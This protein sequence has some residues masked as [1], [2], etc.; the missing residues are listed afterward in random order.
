MFVVNNSIFANTAKSSN[1]IETNQSRDYIIRM[2]RYKESWFC[3]NAFV[4][5]RVFPDNS[6]LEAS[7]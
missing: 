2:E 6:S 5:E 1:M 3:V 7:V 4:L